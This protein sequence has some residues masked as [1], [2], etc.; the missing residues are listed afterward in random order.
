MRFTPYVLILIFSLG[1]IG[2]GGILLIVK[3]FK[4]SVELSS[5]KKYNTYATSG[6]CEDLNEE[7]HETIDIKENSHY[8]LKSYYNVALF[9][10]YICN[11]HLL[12]F[13]T[14][15]FKSH[16]QEV[17]SPPPEV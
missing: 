5:L 7:I 8:Y 6:I 12:R 11:K 10:S 15:L 16:F 2:K 14:L 3:T 13:N 4:P 9:Q 1:I 17:V